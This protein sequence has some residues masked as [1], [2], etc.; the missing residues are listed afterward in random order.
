MPPAVRHSSLNSQ[1][2]AMCSR[3]HWTSSSISFKR[4]STKLG[5]PVESVS[6]ASLLIRR[7]YVMVLRKGVATA[8]VVFDAAVRARTSPSLLANNVTIFLV[9][10]RPVSASMPS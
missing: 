1:H 8:H 7:Q 10:T 9:N 6:N 5:A 3:H 4:C 2:I